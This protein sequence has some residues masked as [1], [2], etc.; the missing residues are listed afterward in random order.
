MSEMGRKKKPNVGG[1]TPRQVVLVYMRKQANK[2]QSK[3]VNH[4]STVSASLPTFRIL[5]WVS[6][7]TDSVTDCDE[8]V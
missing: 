6:A 5:P 7:L 4:S 2:P 1:A 8:K 3:P